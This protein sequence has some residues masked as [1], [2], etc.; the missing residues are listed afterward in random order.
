MTSSKCTYQ[1]FLQL[2]EVQ[3]P[4]HSFGDLIKFNKV[5]LCVKLAQHIALIAKMQL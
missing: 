3:K 1:N 2:F 5:I 4:C